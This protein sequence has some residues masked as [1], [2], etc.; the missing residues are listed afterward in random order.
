MLYGKIPIQKKAFGEH[1]RKKEKFREDINIGC[2][3]QE[4]LSAD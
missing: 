2:N 1:K 3:N 4:E